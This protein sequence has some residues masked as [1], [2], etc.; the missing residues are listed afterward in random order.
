[1]KIIEEIISTLTDDHPVTQV[2]VGVHQ[3]AV[4][5][6]Y[7][8]LSSVLHDE[9]FPHGKPS[10]REAGNL[11]DRT[12]RELAKGAFSDSLLEAA[13]GM[14]AIN[15]LLPIDEIKC[16]ELNALDILKDKGQ[17]K[18]VAVIGH[19]PFIP[20]LR[21]FV[22]ELHVLE[23]RLQ[24]GDLPAEKAEDIL[25][26]SDVVAITATSFINHTL[27]DLLVLCK[28]SFVL[29]LGPTTPL[30]PVLFDHGIDVLCGVQVTEPAK[31]L[32]YISEGAN[33]R[34]IKGIKLLTITKE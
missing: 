5:S 20:E 26:G 17:N 16:K 14:A 7:C 9:E 22:R 34:Q 8:G 21:K 29:M 24:P 25:P 4:I 19:F 10:V 6:K 13:I 32:C 18:K 12:A 2:L 33:F 1:V 31:A 15:S 23:K 27:E 30:T 3:S 28:N 11:T